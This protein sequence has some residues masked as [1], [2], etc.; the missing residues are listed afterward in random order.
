MI[1]YNTPDY[2][3]DLKASYRL[4][5]RIKAYYVSRGIP[6]NGVRFWVDKSLDSYGSKVY[7]VRSNLVHNTKTMKLE[8]GSKYE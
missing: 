6:L 8:V 5:D 2:L 3:G 4:I 7:S 1:N